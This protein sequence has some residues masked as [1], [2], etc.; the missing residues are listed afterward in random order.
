VKLWITGAN[1]QVGS[2][3]VKQA[4]GKG[5]EVIATTRSD[6]DITDTNQVNSFAYKHK[7]DVIINA[8]AYTSVDKAESDLEQ[9]YQVNAEAVK[10]LAQAALKSGIPLFHISTDYVFDGTK[11]SPYLESDP[12][13]PV[14]IYGASKRKGEEF[15]ELSGVKFINLRT[16]WV[17]G[18]EGNNFVKTMVRLANERDEL[19]VIDD[20]IGAPTFAVDIANTLL[21]IVNKVVNSEF[22][23][24]GTYHYSGLPSVTWWEFAKYAIE[25][26]FECGVVSQLPVLNKL[27]TAQY[28]TPAK[29]PINSRLDNEKIQ[30]IFSVKCSDWKAGVCL[31]NQ[32]S[33]KGC[34]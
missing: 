16:S 30:K 21:E 1:G 3:L 33:P 25:H 24:W 14:N 8:A 5:Y 15:L 19:G 28:P 32:M 4:I 9:A 27:T 12:I 20:Q 11:P 17:F 18:T 13:C 7:F 2:A 34:K 22:N 10:L 29:R 6:I 26:A 23:E 31:L